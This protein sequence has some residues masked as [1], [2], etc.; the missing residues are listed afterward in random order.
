MGKDI[1]KYT[2]VKKTLFNV[3]HFQFKGTDMPGGVAERAARG[4]QVPNH[5]RKKF[6]MMPS[7]QF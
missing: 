1:P 7:C 2:D 5:P 6:V 3:M 4:A